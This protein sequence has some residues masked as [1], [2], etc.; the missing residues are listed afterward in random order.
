MKTNMKIFQILKYFCKLA[1]K[2]II[3]LNK[4]D[5][6]LTKIKYLNKNIQKLSK[7]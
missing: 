6:Y 5:K 7:F 2:K 4:F 3:N 1:T